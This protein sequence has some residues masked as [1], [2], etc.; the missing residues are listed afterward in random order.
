MRACMRPRQR[1][2]NMCENSISPVSKAFQTRKRML[3]QT[4]NRM[5]VL[6]EDA[7]SFTSIGALFKQCVANQRDS[8]Q[9]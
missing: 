2:K 3:I 8:V 9:M 1:S 6:Q 7:I 5:R 4:R